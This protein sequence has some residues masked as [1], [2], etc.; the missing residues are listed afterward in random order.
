MESLADCTFLGCD[1]LMDVTCFSVRR[2]LK[3]G[4]EQIL[5]GGINSVV[6]TFFHEA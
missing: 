2:I 5:L 1:G 6:R 4:Y 3:G